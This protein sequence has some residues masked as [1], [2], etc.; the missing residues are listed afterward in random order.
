MR[1]WLVIL[2]LL[3]GGAVLAGFLVAWSGVYNIAASRGHWLVTRMI[4]EFGMQSSVRTHALGIT[5]PPLDEAAL[6]ERGA[7]HF[8][9]SCALCHGAPG[10][11]RNPVARRLI[12]EPPPLEHKV[13]QWKTRELFWIVKHGIKY[14]GMPAWVALKR[15]DEVWAVVAFLEQTPGMSGATY[16][17]LA[18]GDL[19]PAPTTR[20]DLLETGRAG[21]HVAACARCHGYDGQGRESGAFPG[22]AGQ[23]AAY[24]LRALREYAT[25]IRPSGIMQPVAAEL[26]DDEMRALADHYARQQPRGGDRATAAEIEA[27]RLIAQQG[28]AARGIPACDDCHGPEAAADYPRLAGQYAVQTVQQIMLWQQEARGGGTYAA[29]MAPIAKSLSDDDMRAVAAYYASL[30][31]GGDGP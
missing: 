13:T 16:R 9:G 22:I 10:I 5:P 30:A 21:E 12:P 17:K 27:G 4:L 20:R 28:I 25:G 3:L 14:T 18:F 7:A 26:S 29:I 6:I 11:E 2:G 15:D 24:L 31:G 1:R 19:A 8:Q 23:P